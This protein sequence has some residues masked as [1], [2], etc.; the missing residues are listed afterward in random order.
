MYVSALAPTM[1][2]Q[3]NPGRGIAVGWKTSCWRIPAALSQRSLS[4]EMRLSPR[5]FVHHPVRH[6]KTQP[7]LFGKLH[8]QVCVCVYIKF[9]KHARINC[10]VDFTDSYDLLINPHKTIKTKTIQIDIL[11]LNISV[12]HYD[13]IKCNWK[14]WSVLTPSVII[15]WHRK[16][17]STP[18]TVTFH[19]LLRSRQYRSRPTPWQTVLQQC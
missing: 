9:E 2:D 19:W 16:C 5:L 8:G 12:T 3:H 18:Q 13:S 7:Y 17:S 14:T 4:D 1:R 15:K 6:A 11:C 10:G